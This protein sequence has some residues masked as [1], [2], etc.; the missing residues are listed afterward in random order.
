MARYKLTYWNKR[1]RA[2]Q[3]RLLLND[4]GAD[5][6]DVHVKGRAFVQLKD[7]GPEFLTFGS[8]PM[9]EDGDFRLCQGP[10]IMDYLAEAHGIAPKT[11]RPAAKARSI[12][13]GAEDL[14]MRYFTLFG[15][16]GEDR[17]RAFVDG[18]WQSR[19]LPSFDGLLALNGEGPWLVGDH[20]TQADIAV[21]DILDSMTSWVAGATIDEHPRLK[22]WFDSIKARPRIAEYL[23]SN[24]RPSS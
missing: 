24:R 11:P 3:V 13:L 23:T 6:E 10:V 8:V 15:D 9:L 21:W 5:Y 4:L 12:V 22:A 2:E 16:G 18:D 14:R 17:Q 20:M 7:R 19:W 1:G